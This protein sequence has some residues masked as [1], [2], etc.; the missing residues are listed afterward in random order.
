MG[1]R[2]AKE[3]ERREMGRGAEGEGKGSCGRGE[4]SGGRREEEE[5]GKRKLRREGGAE[6]E[7]CGK[8]RCRARR[9]GKGERTRASCRSLEGKREG[10]Q[11]GKRARGK[12]IST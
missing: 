3:G 6:I 4:R 9:G 7:V 8:A 2:K 11:R 5:E 12:V 10:K 1:R